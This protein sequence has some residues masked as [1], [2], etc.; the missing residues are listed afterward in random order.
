MVFVSH[1]PFQKKV[2][3]SQ[4]WNRMLFCRVNENQKEVNFSICGDMF[5]TFL[6]CNV[7]Y[8]DILSFFLSV[9]LNLLNMLLSL[10]TC[11]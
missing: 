1:D 7:I 11:I 4:T 5:L 10:C 3:I 8:F 9:Q 6:G 2:N